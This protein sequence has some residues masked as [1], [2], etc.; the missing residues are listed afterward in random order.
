MTTPTLETPRL[1]LRPLELADA[2]EVQP[3][4]VQ[5]EI[6]KLLNVR[7]PWPFPAERSRNLLSG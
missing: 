1:I 2:T 5:W 6:V 7:V 3:L 4:F